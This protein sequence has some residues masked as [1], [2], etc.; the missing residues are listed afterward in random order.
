MAST[1][2]N[3]KATSS[4]TKNRFRCTGPRLSPDRKRAQTITI[5]GLICWLTWYSAGTPP[6]R[7]WLVW[8]QNLEASCVMKIR[9]CRGLTHLRDRKSACAA[10]SLVLFTGKITRD[11]RKTWVDAPISRAIPTKRRPDIHT[12]TWLLHDP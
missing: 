1:R 11:R 5:C 9:I 10:V 7:A 8:V 2:R 3:N 6:Q 4:V 12:K